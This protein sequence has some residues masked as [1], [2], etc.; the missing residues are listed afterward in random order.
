LRK[1][2][3]DVNPSQGINGASERRGQKARLLHTMGI[4]ASRR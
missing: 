2:V 1:L 4:L 3:G